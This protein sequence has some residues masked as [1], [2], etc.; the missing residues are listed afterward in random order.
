[1]SKSIAIDAAGNKWI[2]A[3][4]GLA[5][6]DGKNWT[7]YQ[8]SNSALPNNFVQSIAIE[9]NGTTWVGTL[10]GGLAKFDGVLGRCIKP[11]I[12]ACRMMT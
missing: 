5:K 3:E 8:S 11:Q 4:G 10:F 1:M 6:F 7:V 2:G 9:G 12:Q